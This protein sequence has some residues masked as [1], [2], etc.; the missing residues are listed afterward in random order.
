MSSSRIPPEPT[1]IIRGLP[2]NFPADVLDLLIDVARSLGLRHGTLR[3]MRAS[4]TP[5]G[6]DPERYVRRFR[7]S[8][9]NAGILASDSAIP[10][11]TTYGELV[12]Y[13]VG[14]VDAAS[15]VDQE[16]V[17]EIFEG[18]TV[19]ALVVP[20]ADVQGD[21]PP[22]DEFSAL[23]G[24]VAAPSGAVIVLIHTFPGSPDL[25]Y[26]DT[27]DV[28]LISVEDRELFE[29]YLYG[30]STPEDRVQ[31]AY[32]LTN[33][34]A[35]QR[36]PKTD[37]DA[38]LQ[39]FNE[40]A[41]L[42]PLAGEGV[43]PPAGQ[44]NYMSFGDILDRYFYALDVLVDI[45]GVEYNVSNIIPNPRDKRNIK[46]PPGAVYSDPYLL[47][48]FIPD[49][50][51]LSCIIDLVNTRCGR[52]MLTYD[53]LWEYMG[54]V[55]SFDPVLARN[56]FCI[57]DLIPIFDA[58]DRE[59]EIM[60]STYRVVYKRNRTTS[61]MAHFYPTTWRFVVTENHV[62]HI[63][64]P[65]NHDVY[66][67]NRLRKTIRVR[68]SSG[69]DYEELMAEAGLHKF[70][71]MSPMM[72]RREMRQPYIITAW[73]E[74]K[75]SRRHLVPSVRDQRTTIAPGPGSKI[76]RRMAFVVLAD[77]S[78]ELP[79]RDDPMA[80]LACRDTLHNILFN[81]RYKDMDMR[82]FVHYGIIKRVI[83]RLVKEYAY[84]PTV[85]ITSR[86]INN[87]TVVSVTS[88]VNRGTIVFYVSY[89]ELTTTAPADDH[90]EVPP[91]ALSTCEQYIEHRR[92]A[93]NFYSELIKPENLSVMHEN[94]ASIVF[95]LAR[96][97][98]VGALQDLRYSLGDGP[99]CNVDFNRMY[100][101]FFRNGGVD[102]G[103]PLVPVCDVYDRFVAYKEQYP[104]N[105][106]DYDLLV[107]HV[108]DTPTVFLDK[109]T[110]LV[111][112][113]H[114]DAFLAQCTT[115]SLVS[116]DASVPMLERPTGTTMICVTAYLR[117]RTVDNKG[118]IWSSIATVWN[119]DVDLPRVL[120]KR[121]L[122]AT[123]GRLYTKTNSS[124]PSASLFLKESEAVEFAQKYRGRSVCI[125][126]DIYFAS[127]SDV[128]TV[129]RLQ[130]AYLLRVLQMDNYRLRLFELVE[131]LRRDH[132]VHALAINTDAVY[133]HADDDPVVREALKDMITPP[134]EI[135]TLNAFGKLK[136]ES[137]V[138]IP[139][140]ARSSSRFNKFIMPDADDMNVLKANVCLTA[141]SDFEPIIV[142]P[143]PSERCITNLD[144]YGRLLL[145]ATVPGAGKSHAVLGTYGS[146]VVVVCPTNS[147][148]V[149]FSRRYPGCTALT[150]HKFLKMSMVSLQSETG[151][152][153]QDDRGCEALGFDASVNDGLDVGEPEPSDASSSSSSS[154]RFTSQIEANKV[155]LIDEIYMYPISILQRLYFRLKVTNAYR[156]FATGDPFQLPPIG[157]DDAVSAEHPS[158][159]AI[160]S[161]LSLSSVPTSEVREHRLNAVNLL[162]PHQMV[163]HEC[164]RAD[165][166][167]D[168]QR[169]TEICRAMQDPNISMD[170][171]RHVMRSNFR[172]LSMR[173][174][175]HMLRE[176]MYECMAVCCYNRTCRSVAKAVLPGGDLTRPG[177]RLVNR[178]YFVCPGG[179]IMMVNYVYEVMAMDHQGL[180]ELG[181]KQAAIWQRAPGRYVCLKCLE[182]DQCFLCPRTHVDQSM[183]WSQ[184]RTCHSL[185]GTSVA[186]GII[187]FNLDS[188]HIT[189]QY[190]YV[191][192]TRARDL[193]DVYLVN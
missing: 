66:K 182:M 3:Q 173:E 90:G 76:K 192:L 40:A 152:A 55:G 154:R 131:T 163:L 136:F 17:D 175:V 108:Y 123:L 122:N 127:E 164:K 130:N 67:F 16:P 103:F 186:S 15:S 165:R 105:L 144:A 56:G 147:L 145:T 48:N 137:D 159:A 63:N 13:V 23:A 150:M 119:A 107:V 128:L 7:R 46:I 132:A 117:C 187:L 19:P 85:S 111:F 71:R 183:L 168:N 99:F 61:T 83:I 38:T 89:S 28:G 102:G 11:I 96:M 33:T 171:I 98:F 26:T 18:E 52:T 8:L 70:I 91:L 29:G 74:A 88:L 45:P 116:R 148:C 39:E 79:N 81:N 133:F 51:W 177:V 190:N 151:S 25:R 97:P 100:P 149:E 174:A 57:K 142:E 10:D 53:R 143:E 49:C 134:G 42:E 157:E 113:H 156:V 30:T 44:R 160:P 9:Q 185:Q 184:T 158:C 36:Y 47:H 72:P 125:D 141:P 21:L 14:L 75:A 169:M 37:V 32:E 50:C 178:R 188:P 27:F 94:V 68:E 138:S 87:I 6:T 172:T 129:P 59:V 73:D 34:D 65:R 110:N 135:D 93:Y 104:N 115:A 92:L 167:E 77:D 41:V 170:G 124:T 114:L 84:R 179:F 176:R 191:A 20:D 95:R 22:I 54:R 106:R 12:N 86:G 109:G 120:R 126:K 58:M 112:K 4:P 35:E 153:Y 64:R 1:S 78:E 140:M 121:A 181:A 162:F 118:A 166:P 155:L 180:S 189:P 24:N 60:D 139:I 62:Y 80:C 5:L 82:V 69:F 161:Y 31:R 43:A 193:S 2:E 146:E 101:S